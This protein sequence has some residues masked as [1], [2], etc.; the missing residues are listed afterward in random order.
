MDSEERAQEEL[1]IS[2]N[3]YEKMLQNK[4]KRKKLD[5]KI[6]KLKIEEED[7]GSSNRSSQNNESQGSSIDGKDY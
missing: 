2:Y 6:K 3:E 1:R 5:L 4:K 7:D